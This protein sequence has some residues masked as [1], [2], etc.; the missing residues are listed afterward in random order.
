MESLSQRPHADLYDIVYRNFSRNVHSADF[1]E[2]LHMNEPAL[3]D[4]RYSEYLESRDAVGC[5][6]AF[7]SAA[8]IADTVNEIFELGF[9]GRLKR[10]I[11][12]RET[13]QAARRD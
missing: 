4:D 12:R 1:A 3:L 8:A 9:K 11:T 10:V 13:L 6:V 2:L 5:E 7:I